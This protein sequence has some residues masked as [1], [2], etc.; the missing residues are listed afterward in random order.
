MNKAYEQ[1]KRLLFIY[2]SKMLSL[3]DIFMLCVYIYI[4]DLLIVVVYKGFF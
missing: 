2:V 4:L 1:H 3:F